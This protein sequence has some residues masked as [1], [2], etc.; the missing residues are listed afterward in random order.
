MKTFVVL[1]A[2]VAAA[3]LVSARADILAD[4]T[5][6]TLPSTNSIIGTGDSPAATQSGVGADIGLGTASASHASSASAWSIPAGNGSSHSWSVNTWAVGD[7]FQFEVN[8]IGFQEIS[9]SYDQIS[10]STGPGIFKFGYSTDGVNFTYGSDYTVL[11]NASPNTW[12]AGTPISSSTFTEDLS[13]I[14]ALN[15]E[16]A[17]FFRVVDD[18]TTSAS[19]ANGGSTAPG[20]SG[21]DRGGQLYCFGDFSA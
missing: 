1:T 11:V 2:A 14:T 5:F 12:S 6:E 4:W 3:S 7:Y 8:T 21:T 20:T 15:G 13:G 19:Q 17:V 18:A 16:A 10:S 9:V